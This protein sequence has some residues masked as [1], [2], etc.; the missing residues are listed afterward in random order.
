MKPRRRRSP[1]R[2]G[3]LLLAI[4]WAGAPASGAL[5]SDERAACPGTGIRAPGWSPGERDRVCVA[6][7][8]AIAFLRAN[9]LAYS[10]GLTIAPLTPG[11]CAYEA[12]VIGQCDVA[13]NEIRVLTYAATAAAA[14]RLPPAFGMP[15][16]RALWES[17]IAHETAHAVAEPNFA[18]GARRRTASEYIAS[19][20]QLATMPTALR[21]AILARYD[22]EAFAGRDDISLLIHDFDPAV[23]AVKSYRHYVALGERRSAFVAG[24]LRE[25]LER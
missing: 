23:F 15:P 8:R 4:A 18:A 14:R 16:S 3:V 22:N 5:A 9:G 20:T 1:A 10:D 17:F 6:S 11:T 7:A 13:R 25:G 24:L 21:D 12:G 19:V 2:I